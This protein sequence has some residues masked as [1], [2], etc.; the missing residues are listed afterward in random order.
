MCFRTCL[1]LCEVFRNASLHRMRPHCSSWKKDRSCVSPCATLSHRNVLSIVIL[2]QDVFDSEVTLRA[3]CQG[4]DPQQGLRF[5]SQA[6]S[7]HWLWNPF[8]AAIQWVPE[9]LSSLRR[10]RD[11]EADH[12]AIPGVEVKNARA[13]MQRLSHSR[14]RDSRSLSVGLVCSQCELINIKLKSKLQFLLFFGAYT[15]NVPTHLFR[16]SLPPPP[17]RGL[18]K[19]T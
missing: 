8:H 10:R 15:F 19:R 17:S 7:P 9:S 5:Y 4:F 13:P 1:E 16:K 6:P 3:G 12:S 2:S 14:T 18:P 11:R